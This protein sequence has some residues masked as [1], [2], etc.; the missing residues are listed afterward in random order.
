VAR[1]IRRADGTDELLADRPIEGGR[2]RIGV[3]A[4]DQAYRFRLDGA[5]FGPPA[6]GRVLH[7][8]P[9]GSF[10]GAYLGMYASSNGEPSTTTAD[11]AYFEYRAL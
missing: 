8:E 4:H 2:V 10:T 11:F 1:L 6:D 9:A 5:E 7:H 3:E